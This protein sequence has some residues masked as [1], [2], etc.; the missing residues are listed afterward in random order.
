[1][2]CL[3]VKKVIYHN[4]S[5]FRFRK[6]IS[7]QTA[8]LVSAAEFFFKLSFLK[9][10]QKLDPFI[11]CILFLIYESINS[12]LTCCK[13]KCLGQICFLNYDPKTSRSVRIQNSWNCNIPQAGWGTKLHF[14]IWLNIS[15]NRF[16]QSF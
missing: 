6:V 4:I 15:S 9:F 8:L 1:M 7:E 11:I 13:A 10:L 3:Q 5:C 12:F 2:N 16:T 14:C